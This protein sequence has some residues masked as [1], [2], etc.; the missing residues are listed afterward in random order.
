MKN[1]LQQA[2]PPIHVEICTRSS[3]KKFEKKRAILPLLSYS[4]EIESG[5]LLP[6]ALSSKRVLAHET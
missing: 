1:I 4:S 2:P 6:R 5:E 3:C